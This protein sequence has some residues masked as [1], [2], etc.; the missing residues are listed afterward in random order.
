MDLNLYFDPVGISREEHRNVPEL[1]EL[2]HK[3]II[4][5]PD[6]PIS[7]ISQ[8][9]IAILGV[10]EDR[11]AIRPGSA[12]APDQIRRKLYA[13]GKI[14]N[15]I[16][17]TDLGNMKV[18]QKVSDTYAGLRDIL[19]FLLENQVTPVIIGGS[20]DLTISSVDALIPRQKIVRL[21]TIDPRI[22][23]VKKSKKLT[24]DTYL[25]YILKKH[26]GNIRYANLG[27]QEFL[28]GN[29]NLKS[30]R[31]KGHE[32]YRLGEIRANLPYFEAIIR[33][34]DLLSVDLSSIRQADAPGT[35]YPIPS[36]FSVDEICQLAMYAGLSPHLKIYSLYEANPAS[37]K[38]QQT[39]FLAAQTIWYFLS[40]FTRRKN[41]NPASGSNRFTEY[42]I[43]LPDTDYQL[44]FRKSEE[45]GRWWIKFPDEVKPAG[46]RSW[47]AC[48]Y[49]DYQKA[50]QQEIPQR[51][52]KFFQ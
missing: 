26:T 23:L 34:G 32:S 52:L 50:T 16:R 48:S 24:S 15:K 35:N 38:E 36:G 3:L 5:T 2:S 27:H 9:D 13:L 43:T 29:K 14:N 31:I 37:D 4:H 46:E 44:V 49:E 6:F 28:S 12:L 51:W 8:F 33:D 19:F 45:T 30:L 21:V 20:Q 22:D 47:I 41:E 39:A 11:N 10:P 25:A 18:G 40:G 1:D 17:I 7:R 42:I